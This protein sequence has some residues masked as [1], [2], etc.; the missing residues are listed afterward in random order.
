MPVPPR[1]TPSVTAGRRSGTA[2]RSRMPF[3]H[4]RVVLI[5]RAVLHFPVAQRRL[6]V[7][8]VVLQIRHGDRQALDLPNRLFDAG[9]RPLDLLPQ[10]LQLIVQRTARGGRL[11]APLWRRS[12]AAGSATRRSGRR[13]TPAAGRPFLHDGILLPSASPAGARRSVTRPSPPPPPTPPARGRLV[14]PRP[15]RLGVSSPLG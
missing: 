8:D 13:P 11:G 10:R 1:S 4:F 15:A 6:K 9:G 12:H 3:P 7:R 14:P 2:G 5:H